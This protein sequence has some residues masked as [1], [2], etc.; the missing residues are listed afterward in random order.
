MPNRN[1]SVR[2]QRLLILDGTRLAVD[3]VIAAKQLGAI[4][5]VADYNPIELAPA[6]AVADEHYE[7]DLLNVNAVLELINEHAITGVVAGFSDRILPF[8]AEIC[9][10]AGL[11]C[12]GTSEL[13][14]LFTNKK[15]Y[16]E[17]CEKFNVP[18][19]DSYT[20]A[21]ALN[22][23][24]P[25]VAFPLLIKPV[26]GSGSR[27]IVICSSP[28]ELENS[29]ISAQSASFS[30]NVIIERYLSGEEATVF[31][32]FQDGEYYVSMI[33]NRHLA[34]TPRGVLPVPLGYSAPAKFSADYMQDIAPQ[35]K[36]MLASVD[37]RNGMMFMQGILDNGVFRAYDIG[38]RLT[39]SLEFHLLEQLSGY[40]PLKMLIHF[41]F[42]G[43]MGEEELGKKA[44][45]FH[46][47]YGF[48]VSTLMR[49]GT[50][51]D[52]QGLDEVRQQDNIIAV[53]AAY[54]EN[55]TLPN[56]ALGELRQIAVRTLGH[57]NSFSELHNSIAMV[58][59]SLKILDQNGHD[60]TFQ[61]TTD[62]VDESHL[63]SI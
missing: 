55:E 37:V 46:T 31:W 16:K 23:E 44:S 15:R 57:A 24:I 34:V 8:Y 63:Y 9:E 18:T 51:Y 53:R 61:S 10:Q 49:P 27:G 2:G 36:A 48:N 4:T 42:T 29:L 54:A 7:V 52:L 20:I 6:K 39:G 40:N 3:I 11:P 22:G 58:A 38:F 60:L 43:D 14:K 1:D 32:V 19:I 12:Y 25:V 21:Q 50:I 33:A 5:V 41:A 56:E 17:L 45:P 26:D 59:G 47:K 28:D 62:F 13:F 30:G 35:V